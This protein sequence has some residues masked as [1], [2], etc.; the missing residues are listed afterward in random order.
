MTRVV[1]DPARYTVHRWR[2]RAPLSW[3]I[4][5]DPGN[6]RASPEA[7]LQQL[8]RN[9]DGTSYNELLAEYSDGIYS[10]ILASREWYVG[11]AGVATRIPGT[12]VVNGAVNPRT[13]G[14]SVATYGQRIIETNPPLYRA[15]VD[16]LVDLVHDLDLPDAGVI[17][18]HREIN[19][20]RGRRSDPRGID[21]EQL[22]QD[23]AAKLRET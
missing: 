22:R 5:H 9:R 17:L 3:L 11:H 8:R 7:T 23:V 21:M 6:D 18:S 13:W 4:V 2:R 12:A 16:R 10:V 19:T 15:T 14:L 20:V 1:N